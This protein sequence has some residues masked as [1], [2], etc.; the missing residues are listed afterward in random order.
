MLPNLNQPEIQN[1]TPEFKE[2]TPYGELSEMSR[3]ELVQLY[4]EKA[5]NGSPVAIMRLHLIL[6]ELHRRDAQT[7]ERAMLRNN[8]WMTWLTAFITLLTLVNV[9]VAVLQ[10]F[11]IL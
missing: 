7:R 6:S 1:L 5:E 11:G 10:T 3:E 4:N 2:T 9:V 8:R